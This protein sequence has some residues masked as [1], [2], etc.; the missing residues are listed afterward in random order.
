MT[1]AHEHG[2][3][4][5]GHDHHPGHGHG[6]VHGAG[7]ERRVFWVMLLTA[8]YMV[9]EAIGGWLAGSLAL[10]ADA[11]HM[12]TDVGALG[13]AWVAFRMTRRPA[14]PR[15]SYG[16]DRFQ[17]LAAFVNGIALF[18]I[19]LWIVVEAVRRFMSPE[20]V[21]GLE[22]FW[23]ALA[24]LLV[25]ILA[26][27]LL[28]SGGRENI[29]IRGALLHVLGDLLGSVAAIVAALVILWT[30][31]FPIDPLLSVLVSLLLLRSAWRLIGESGHILLEG[32]PS[33][34]D[35][36][37]VRTALREDVPDVVDVHHVHVWS[38]TSERPLLTLHAVLREAGDDRRTL[39][40]IH[41][42]LKTRFK[43]EHAT[44]Q[45]E[46]GLCTDEEP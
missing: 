26:F 43:V 33:G 34:L 36:A 27:W 8:G 29:N 40:Q 30:G 35:P 4:H 11:A 17:V 13:L 18:V 25:N 28:N 22:M 20:P 1:S 23:I 37:E 14:D 38:L 41:A 44:V 24:G 42:S 7:S 39:R 21:L 16:Y 31:W 45:L 12:L 2:P 32:T 19:A 3:G 5:A 46:R 9:V 15:R 10:L 6:H